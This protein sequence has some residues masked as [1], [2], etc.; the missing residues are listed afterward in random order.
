MNDM[1][2][3]VGSEIDKNKK[4][5]EKEAMK[6][7][8]SVESVAKTAE[9]FMKKNPEKAAAIAAGIGAALGAA[10]TLLFSSGK[11]KGKK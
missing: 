10:A 3:K 1:K 2:A 4:L 7:K 9:D 6:M 5:V 8:K 11:K